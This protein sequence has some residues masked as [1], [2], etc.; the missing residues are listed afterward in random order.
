[1]RKRRFWTPDEKRRIVDKSL[2]D[3]ASIAEVDRQHDLNANQLFAWRRQFPES[4]SARSLRSTRKPSF[5][6]AVM[7]HKQNIIN[8]CERQT[9]AA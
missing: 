9:S 8:S 4:A 7:S 1:M 3:G 2:E 5:R 6:T